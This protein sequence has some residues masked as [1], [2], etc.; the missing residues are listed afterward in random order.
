MKFYCGTL[1]PPTAIS[2]SCS[3]SF[4]APGVD[5]LVVV[6]GSSILELWRL[7]ETDAGDG[8]KFRRIGMVNTFS[9]ISS[10]S[11]FRVEISEHTTNSMPQR[12]LLV[13]TGE[14]GFVTIVRYTAGTSVW[15][16]K[17]KFDGPEV[18]H[19]YVE[20]YSSQEGT[21]PFYPMVY[22]PLVSH[23]AK[24]KRPQAGVTDTI[25]GGWE[26]L[27]HSK[28]ER[29]A[30]SGRSSPICCRSSH[31]A[32]QPNCMMFAATEKIKICLQIGKFE[33]NAFRYELTGASADPE[34]ADEM[35][36]DAEKGTSTFASPCVI[37]NIQRLNNTNIE[38]K[39]SYYLSSACE[40]RDESRI[41]LCLVALSLFRVRTPESKSASNVSTASITKSH[42]N[43][44]YFASLE[45]RKREFQGDEENDKSRYQ[46]QL[47]IVVYEFNPLNHSINVL[48]TLPVDPS[49]H[50]LFAVPAGEVNLAP[51]AD[52]HSASSALARYS[53]APGGII[54]CAG[55]SCEWI[56]VLNLFSAESTGKVEKKKVV[57]PRRFDMAPEDHI[58]VISGAFQL[59]SGDECI[60]LV[61]TA[62]GDVYRV[63]VQTHTVI[64]AD[65][66]DKSLHLSQKAGVS[67]F[68]VRY[69]ETIPPA[70]SMYLLDGGRHLF[71]V[72]ESS[73]HVLYEMQPDSEKNET[74]TETTFLPREHTHLRP[75]QVMP[76]CSGMTKVHSCR[77]TREDESATYEESRLVGLCGDGTKGSILQ[78]RREIPSLVVSY[79]ALN[80]NFPVRLFTLNQKSGNK[81]GGLEK[82]PHLLVFSYFDGTLVYSMDNSFT[83][84]EKILNAPEEPSNGEGEAKPPVVP[85]PFDHPTLGTTVL[86]NGDYIHI[87]KNKLLH[88]INGQF[89]FWKPPTDAE[90]FLA[91]AN[92]SQIVVAVA[93]K[94]EGTDG[95]ESQLVYFLEY[96]RLDDLGTLREP[97]KLPLNRRPI[98]ISLSSR[99]SLDV[100]SPF[101]TIALEGGR[102][103]VWELGKGSIG[104][105][106][107][108]YSILAITVPFPVSSLCLMANDCENTMYC[109]ERMESGSGV[110]Q[111]AQKWSLF[112]GYTNGFAEEKLLFEQNSSDVSMRSL[113]NQ[114]YQTISR[115]GATQQDVSTLSV[116]SSAMFRC[117]TEPVQFHPLSKE[118]TTSISIA[119]RTAKLVTMLYNFALAISSSTWMV[120]LPI[121]YTPGSS[122][123][124]STSGRWDQFAT[125][126]SLIDVPVQDI[127]FLGS[128]GTPTPP[129]SGETTQTVWKFHFAV[130]LRQASAL[131]VLEIDSRNIAGFPLSSYQ[132]LPIIAS[133]R[134]AA[135]SGTGYPLCAPPEEAS[136]PNNLSAS[137]SLC[138]AMP[139]DIVCVPSSSLGVVIETSHRCFSEAERE[140]LRS[141][142]LDGNT[143]VKTDS[144][145]DT[146]HPVKAGQGNWVS[147]L[148]VVDLS[149]TRNF[150]REAATASRA[151]SLPNAH[152]LAPLT[153]NGDG[154]TKDILELDENLAALSICWIRDSNCF[155]VG[156]VRDYVPRVQ[157]FSAGVLLLFSCTPP[158]GTTDGGAEEAAP[159]VDLLHTTDIDGIPHALCS[160]THGEDFGEHYVAVGAGNVLQIFS[161]G[162]AHM[163]KKY[164]HPEFPSRIVSIRSMGD[165]LYIAD[166][167][168]S[169]FF[170]R[171]NIHPVS[172]MPQ[173][174]VFAD[175]GVM[176]WITAME[177][178]DYNTIAAAD[179]YGNFFV[180]RVPSDADDSFETA[181][182]SETELML[183]QIHHLNRTNF[184]A[185]GGSGGF[186][187]A[188]QQKGNL[189]AHFFVGD[190]ITSIQ[191]TQLDA[192]H[193]VPGECFADRCHTVFEHRNPAA[194]DGAIARNDELLATLHTEFRARN[195]EILL[196]STINGAIGYFLP[197]A[198][199]KDGRVLEKAQA[200]FSQCGPLRCAEKSSSGSVT[201]RPPAAF[202][203]TSSGSSVVDNTFAFSMNLSE[204]AL[205]GRDIV[206]YRSILSPCMG[207]I[208][209]DYIH[210]CMRLWSAT[211]EKTA[212]SDLKV[213]I[214]QFVEGG[215]STQEGMLGVIQALVGIYR[216]AFQ[217]VISL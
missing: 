211:A 74:A 95:A 117:G 156:A 14:S 68:S 3:G 161:V 24:E 171:W 118:I 16:G 94:V 108:I 39:Q 5:E 33:K 205:L 140:R 119:G 111:R 88:F 146:V 4:T 127:G 177:V 150:E 157:T 136:S 47:D 173:C 184:Y 70:R 6:R 73:G 210:Q 31:T 132:C 193:T 101:L 155:L 109:V 64:R 38:V 67:E 203:F 137:R 52:E 40:I 29:S 126:T 141:A 78:F 75:V 149:P 45:I 114:Q 165:R 120:T 71:T 17:S 195:P 179:K 15:R 174:R 138:S 168:E 144:H 58:R 93:R 143:A 181:E 99:T 116:R 139:R 19:E 60:G 11:G 69:L 148:R 48:A 134:G 207:V 90:L 57:F 82:E 185:S 91:T 200:F 213:T 55:D 209:G 100:C 51:Q 9:T 13:I 112:I 97:V 80:E 43:F 190:V 28:M 121:T 85:I 89:R 115:G 206:R 87:Q 21:S 154:I 54:A 125:R 163:L 61:G 169:V 59:S 187:N 46:P 35:I 66:L 217:P 153:G 41:C 79:K 23:T 180:L 102:V 56:N 123:S 176:R 204:S 159:I 37:P 62:L 42:D 145:P 65:L 191:R 216:A 183:K 30:M 25:G 182:E 130:L 122:Q 98:C 129:P 86:T 147:F 172:G 188:C 178:I 215:K 36:D 92:A 189:I 12:D 96:F 22:F 201:V 49:V 151:S 50:A 113:G 77:I 152:S 197:V 124:D 199:T 198:S 53:G 135:T 128:E 175:D 170:A 63:H 8:R 44:A 27:F 186:L 83:F 7:G 160:L 212:Q 76:S 142:A 164:V 2:S 34:G 196:Y 131:A 110:F 105:P 194:H 167:M 20:D 1:Q 84:D 10:V 192:S 158:T 107:A 208:D 26:R 202:P 106:D 32:M 18:H 103:E 72:G 104:R 166:A 214:Q 81:A 133:L 162:K